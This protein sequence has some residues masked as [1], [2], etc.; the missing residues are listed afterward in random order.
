MPAPFRPITP[1]DIASSTCKEHVV[2]CHSA[3]V[4][5]SAL[6]PNGH[7]VSHARHRLAGGVREHGVQLT[8]DTLRGVCF[9][10]A[11]AIGRI[12]DASDVPGKPQ[13]GEEEDDA[14]ETLSAI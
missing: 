14:D 2:Q 7:A 10:I 8:I 11:T 9:V 6:A 5:V 4:V 12:A 3:H 13:V 1:K